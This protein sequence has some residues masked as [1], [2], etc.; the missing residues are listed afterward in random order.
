[1]NVRALVIGEEQLKRVAEVIQY[2][3]RHVVDANTLLRMAETGEGSVGNDV[4][5]RC[6]FPRGY[7]CVYSLEI[8][9][10]LGRCR[11]LSISVDQGE[12]PPH[13]IAVM[14]IAKLFGFHGTLNDMVAV[15]KE[16]IGP[17]QF[18]LNVL[19]L[20]GKAKKT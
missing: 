20:Y 3:E 2:A 13:P 6:D 14:E 9:P 16:Q 1:M 5:F 11:H 17:N 4:N 12:V 19:Q 18:A 7:V 10:D 8:Q 15:W